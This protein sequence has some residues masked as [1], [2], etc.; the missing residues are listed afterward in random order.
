MLQSTPSIAEEDED[1][2]DQHY[3]YDRLQFAA[4]KRADTGLLTSQHEPLPSIASTPTSVNT[5]DLLQQRSV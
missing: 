4:D 3:D 2:V 5:D 1:P